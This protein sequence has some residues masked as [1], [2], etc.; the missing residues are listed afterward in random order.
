[1]TQKKPLKRSKAK[2]KEGNNKKK[3]KEFILGKAKSATPN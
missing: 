2:N 1:M 3:E